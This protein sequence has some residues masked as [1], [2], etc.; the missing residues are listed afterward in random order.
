M[1]EIITQNHNSSLDF[2][3]ESQIELI[4]NTLCPGIT[5]DELKLF[6][7]ACK[8]SGLCPFIKQIY[9][10]KRGKGDYSKMTIQTGIDG[11]RLIAERSKKYIPGQEPEFKYLKDGRLFSATAYVKKLASDGSW[12]VVAATAFYDEYVQVKQDGSP[13]SMWAKMP[14]AMLAKCA[15]ALALKKCF[16][17]ELS[18]IYSEEEMSQA[19]N[20][21][22]DIQPVKSPVL[23]DEPKEKKPSKDDISIL[24]AKIAK[25]TEEYQVEVHENLKKWGL[26]KLDQINIHQYELLF[27]DTGRAFEAKQMMKSEVKNA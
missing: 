5:N 17:A 11:Y 22:L 7:F 19:D 1:S 20:P 4:K 27:V 3:T 13:N 15:E 24:R 6:G 21:V 10:V 25:C 12:H 16:P 23:L 9:P 26:E 8:N 2:W 14:R 18:G